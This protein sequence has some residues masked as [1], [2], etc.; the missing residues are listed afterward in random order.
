[1]MKLRCILFIVLCQATFWAN[2][3]SVRER[4]NMDFSWRF[5][6]GHAYD[7]AKDFNNGTAY[8]SY[9]TK[10]G[11]GDGPADFYFEDRTWRLIDLP[12]DWNM[13]LPFDSTGSHSH[14]Y[15]AIGRNF[16]GNSIGWY[17]KTFTV[18]EADLGKKISVE[19][20]GVHRDSKVWVNGF[21]L[22]ENHSGYNSFA[23]DITDYLNYGGENVIAVRVD[24]T[25]EEG[26]YYEGA[27]IYRHVWLTKNAP[28]H[29]ARYGTFITTT[30]AGDT[31][32]LAIRTTIN[33][34][35]SKSVICDV[36]QYIEDAERQ[37]SSRR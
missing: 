30:L 2:G 37:D 9:Y 33:N 21:Y 1:M 12:H 24:A 6:L 7:P 14:G 8:F 32:K 19:F 31:A 16:P 35:F 15:R 10:T 34:E 13:E 23:Y 28:L 11:Y 18:P 5:A 3:Q 25:I 36:G 27:G 17:R 4:I 20:D 29:V 26:W 22:G